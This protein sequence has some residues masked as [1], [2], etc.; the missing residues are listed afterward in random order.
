[1]RLSELRERNRYLEQLLSELLRLRAAVRAV[2]PAAKPANFAEVARN[3][4][5]DVRL[6][7]PTPRQ[8]GRR[9]RG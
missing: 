7:R 4:R 1:M 9:Q 6:K 2:D 3:T 8:P 5:D